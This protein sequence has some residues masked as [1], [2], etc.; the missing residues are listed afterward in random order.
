GNTGQNSK[1]SGTLRFM[2]YNVHSFKKYGENNDVLTKN[3]MLNIIKEQQPDVICF[4]E[5]YSR[6][7]GEYDIIDSLKRLL[8]TP[9]Y[10]FFPSSKN[11]YE[12]TGMAIFS[13]FPIKN[14]THVNFDTDGGNGSIYVDIMYNNRPLRIYNI[15]LRSISFEKQDYSYLDKVKKINPDKQ[16]SKRIYRM[17]R[18]AFKKRAAHVAVMKA[19]LKKCTTSY[20]IAGDFND[21]PASY[22]VQQLTKGHNNAFAEQGK[23]LGRTYNGKFPNFQIDYILSTK[24]LAIVNYKITEAKLSDHF[25]VRA[26]LKFK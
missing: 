2:T 1:E 16:S 23:G 19:E 11:S 7:K 20:I 4:Q 5:F 3:K 14:P 18:D 25:P 6:N 15:H 21:T 10:Y 8:K 17:L 12:G 13:K 22:A 26:D 9:H 24:D